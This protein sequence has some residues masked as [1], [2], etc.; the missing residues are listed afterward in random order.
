MQI[1]RRTKA[2]KGSNK[3]LCDPFN[4]KKEKF[5]LKLPFPR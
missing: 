1:E 2:P 5:L 3:P 4:Y